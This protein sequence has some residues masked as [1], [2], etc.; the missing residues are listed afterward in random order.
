MRRQGNLGT[1]DVPRVCSCVV[2]CA[3]FVTAG[4]PQLVASAVAVGPAQHRECDPGTH[5]TCL[6]APFC[7]MGIMWNTCEPVF[8]FWCHGDAA[9]WPLLTRASDPD[10][11]R[12]ITMCRLEISDSLS[13]EYA[14]LC[15]AHTHPGGSQLTHASCESPRSVAS[16]WVYLW[17]SP[18]TPAAL[19]STS[20]YVCVCASQGPPIALSVVLESEEAS[21]PSHGRP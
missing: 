7:A 6:L 20:L 18:Y 13:L 14:P 2:L 11:R 1:E 16:R 9:S 10:G 5:R 17:V 19:I 15:A 21:R 12:S 4:Q 3:R 8:F